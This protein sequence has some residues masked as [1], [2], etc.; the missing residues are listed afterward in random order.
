VLSTAHP[1]KFPDTIREAL[2]IDSTHPTL[3]ELKEKEVVK[4][5]VEPA[6]DAIKAFMRER[7]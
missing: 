6:P 4:H 7:N 1:A 2:S 5:F 3:E